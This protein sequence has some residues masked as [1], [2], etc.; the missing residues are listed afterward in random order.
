MHLL[1]LTQTSSQSEK[2]VETSY[3]RDIKLVKVKTKKYIHGSI[4]HRKGWF[5]KDCVQI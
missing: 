1:D 3:P 4:G 5:P 2:K